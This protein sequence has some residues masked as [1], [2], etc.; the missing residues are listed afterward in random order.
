M[1]KSRYL[2]LATALALAGVLAIACGGNNKSS[3]TAASPTARPAATTAPTAR[4][5]ATPTQAAAATAAGGG[6]QTLD[7]AAVASLKF[8]K[9]DLTAKAGG[10]I[11]VRF[12]NRDNGIP[13]NFA[14]YKDSSAGQT[15]SQGQI[16]TG[17]CKGEV[18]L[19]GLT[20]GRYFFRCDVHP[21]QMTG[22]LTVQ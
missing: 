2:V 8:D 3:S 17:P 14:V 1:L 16:C 15:L 20:A 19:T 18:T 4:P 6:P 7:I 12:D 21:T 13:H 22:T 10:T 11:T 9:S 5:A